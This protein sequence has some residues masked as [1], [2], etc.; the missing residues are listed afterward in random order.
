MSPTPRAIT[1]LLLLSS[2]L[3]GLAQAALL[4]PFEGFDETGHYS[5]IQQVAETG[6]WPRWGDRMSKE[7][8]GYFGGAPAP[9]S[10][11]RQWSYHSF[12]T[13]P[14]DVIS[15]ARDAIHVRPAEPRAW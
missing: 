13:A 11:P 9:D 10:M 3:L 8:D 4:P 15:R 1:A 14:A 6:R 5:Y 7:V 2:L 12:F